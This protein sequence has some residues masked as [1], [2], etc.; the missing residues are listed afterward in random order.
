MM[1]RID[2]TDPSGGS[3][4]YIVNGALQQ[5][6]MQTGGQWIDLSSSYT[7]QWSSWNSAFTGYKNSLAGWAGVG[8]YTY[9]SNGETIRIYNIIVNPSLADSLFQHS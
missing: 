3:F 6:W 1:I 2:F 9:T 5:A 4:V 7:S 8:D